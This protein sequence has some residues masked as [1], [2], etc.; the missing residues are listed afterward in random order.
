MG[1]RDVEV[2]APTRTGTPPRQTW[3]AAGG[4]IGAVLASSCCI[5]PLLLLTLGVSRRLVLREARECHR[6]QNGVVGGVPAGRVCREHRLV[7]AAV[8]LTS[9]FQ[10][11]TKEIPS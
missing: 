6:H 5:A 4:V 2:T 7:G 9:P 10:I 8:L 3:F 1:I 11:R